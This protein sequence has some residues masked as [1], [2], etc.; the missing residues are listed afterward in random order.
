MGKNRFLEHDG[1]V[2]AQMTDTPP[3]VKKHKK[4]PDFFSPLWKLWTNLWIS[5]EKWPQI[6]F[7]SCYNT[8]APK[9]TA[10]SAFSCLKKQD[11]PPPVPAVRPRK[12][13]KVPFKEK[14]ERSKERTKTRNDNDL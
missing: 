13:F 4:H 3:C 2:Q 7:F 10:F 9:K 8:I 1:T 5:S 14:I 12:P 11:T 6:L